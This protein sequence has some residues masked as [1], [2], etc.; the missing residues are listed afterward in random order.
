MTIHSTS[1]NQRAA[2]LCEYARQNQSELRIAEHKLSCGATVFDF[3]VQCRGGFAAGVV[4]AR[5]CMADLAEIDVEPSAPSQWHSPR[6]QVI[7]DHPVDACMS[8]QYAGW[9]VKLENFFAMGSGP[10]RAKR[11]KEH[12]LKQLGIHDADQ[13]AV[14]VLE[15]DEIPNDDV[16][17]MMASECNISPEQLIV[18]VAPTRSIAGVIQVVARSVETSLHKL[19]ELGFDLRTIVSAHGTAPLPPPAKDFVKGIGRTNDSIL[20]GGHVSLWVDCEDAIIES[21]G[22]KVPSTTS[23]DYGRPFAVTFKE[24]EYDF[25]KVDPALFSPAMV[26]IAN[27]K[28]GRSWRFGQLRPDIL[29][30]SFAE[31]LESNQ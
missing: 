17:V 5:I 18:C 16:C 22:P 8:S 14:G 15:C 4:L 12:V 10:M 24:Y 3:G 26:T 1:L 7:T 20:Y 13:C 11:G 2:K 19:F 28:S 6:V 27:L 29:A 25:Y 31:R 9:P 21:L 23:R 30:E